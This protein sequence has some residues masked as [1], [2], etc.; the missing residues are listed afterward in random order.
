MKNKKTSP[1]IE[2]KKIVSI[3]A[4]F[5]MSAFISLSGIGFAIYSYITKTKLTVLTSQIHGAVFGA[6]IAFLGI[7]YFLSVLK[8]RKEV[9]KSSSKFSWSNFKK[10]KKQLSVK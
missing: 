6:V 3:T 4:L 9:Y 7:R 8:L 2:K 10:E 5:I 1:K